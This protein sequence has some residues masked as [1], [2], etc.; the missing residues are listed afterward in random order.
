[1]LLR[2]AIQAESLAR[3]CIETFL[4]R[5]QLWPHFRDEVTIEKFWALPQR[6]TRLLWG[7][8][9]DLSW[10]QQSLD[11]SRIADVHLGIGG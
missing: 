8:P 3:H 2:R 9:L 1:V 6:R 7:D 11:P 4:D 10:L 5:R